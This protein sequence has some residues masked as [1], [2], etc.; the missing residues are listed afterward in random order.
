MKKLP[1]GIQDFRA[2]RQGEYLYV[3][4]TELIFQL[5]DQG[6][7]YF[8]SRPR[9]FGKSLLV[10]TLKELFQGNKELFEGLWIE[11]KWDWEEAY[12]VIHISYNDVGYKEL[13]LRE[14][15]KKA[16]THNAE[17]HGISLE[18]ESISLRFKELIHKLS[19][20]NRVV[21]LIDE[22]DKPLID[23]IN[24]P[25]LLDK[26]RE[27]L[28]EF[29][30]VIKSA[31]PYLQ[32]VLLTGVSRFSKVSI[33]SDLN[34]LNDITIDP[35]FS[36]LCGY[37]QQELEHSF[38][39]RIE[40]LAQKQ[41]IEKSVLLEQVK[42]WY[43]GYSWLGK[44]RLYNPFS[45]LNFFQKEVF[46]NY[47]FATG[48]P[49]FLIEVLKKGFHFN[50]D[51]LEAGEAQLGVLNLPDP[52]YR[53][54]LF[55]TG[56]LTIKER[57]HP[58]YYVLGYPNKEVKSSLLQF[59]VEAYSFREEGFPLA[60]KISRALEAGD[61]EKFISILNSLFAA[62]PEKIFRQRN[63]AA[64]HAIVYT[65]LSLMG[66]YIDAEVSAGD[67]IVDAVVKTRDFIYVIE[68]KYGEPPES[69]LQQI[70]EKKYAE[71]FRNDGRELRLVGISFGKE[72]KGV[73]GWEEEVMV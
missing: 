13:G 68:F 54:L 62:I 42:T 52:D 58:L 59:L 4:K 56:Y 49:N 7:Y 25:D 67:G 53:S 71:P 46:Q 55:Q 24:D 34:N 21:L 50:L 44:E 30:S 28:R 41:G 3:D 31:D 22:Y 1:I 2:L 48:T 15:I 39:D 23:F 18:E 72:V 63:E 9:R 66:C 26:N 32:F 33:F 70:R 73:T 17:S 29:Y 37:T 40:A 45:V 65:T 51:E 35:N 43:N 69:A 60:L 16:L 5:A 14:A 10:S 61:T 19:A 57:P 6:K 36:S 64:Y 47:W 27:I 12:P 8:L 11:D 38:A 20:K